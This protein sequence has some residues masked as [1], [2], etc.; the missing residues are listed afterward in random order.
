MGKR[1][2]AVHLLDHY[3]TMLMER[4]GTKHVHSD[5]HAELAQ[6]VDDIIDAS[7]SATLQALKDE[8]RRVPMREGK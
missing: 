4:T 7:V 1:D 8:L 3:V 2:D 5:T 6:L